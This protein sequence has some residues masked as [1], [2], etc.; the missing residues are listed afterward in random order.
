MKP[1]TKAKGYLRIVAWLVAL[2]AMGA[3]TETL[4][5]E[6]VV[7]GVSS[8]RGGDSEYNNYNAGVGLRFKS[9]LIAGAYYNSYR[10]PT[11]Y[12][13][14][15][16]MPLTYIGGFAAVA[17]GYDHVSNMPV[18]L[19]GGLVARLPVTKDVTFDVR[20]L[21]RIKDNPEV[22]HIGLSIDVPFLE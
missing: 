18:S 22:M 11:A 15:E 6:L 8:H 7:H 10:N 1:N 2:I 19:I 21:P 12:I 17:T 13:G 5:S 20:Y 3:A 14:Y 16:W 9:G 4:G